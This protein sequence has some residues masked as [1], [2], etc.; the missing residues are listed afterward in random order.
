[1]DFV[2]PY[3][4]GA[5]LYLRPFMVGSGPQLGL[6]PSNEYTFIVVAAPVGPYYGSAVPA[7]VV[8]DYDRAAPQGV[9]QVKCAGNYAADIVPAAR[10]KKEG[11][12]ICLYLDAR[13]HRHVE[14]FSTS[15]FVAITKD[16][17]YL[18]PDSVSVLDSVTNASLEK[19]AAD[20]GLKV[21]RRKI[22]F[23]AEVAARTSALHV[24]C[25]WQVRMLSYGVMHIA[26]PF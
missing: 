18:T 24:P 14:E 5:S 9:G 19:L 7:V 25:W 3:G 17:V 15:N 16:N 12:P 11:F 2:P 4:S 1:M 10:A 6:G 21:E 20:M 8:D 26:W 13:E 23:E 22:D